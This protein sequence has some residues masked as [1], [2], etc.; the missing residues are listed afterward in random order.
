MPSKQRDITCGLMDR[1]LHRGV[2]IILAA[3]ISGCSADVVRFDAP[4]LDFDSAEAQRKSQPT[5]EAGSLSEQSPNASAAPMTLTSKPYPPPSATVQSDR[6]VQLSTTAGRASQPLS[7]PQTSV[8]QTSAP[9]AENIQVATNE[10]GQNATAPEASGLQAASSTP[11]QITVR[12]G[13]TLYRIARR[14]NMTVSSLKKANGL[15]NDVIRPGQVLTLRSAVAA[16]PANSTSS[17][18][19][20]QQ[21]AQAG[22]TK[23]HTVKTGETLYS[24]ARRAGVS[25]A[26]LK[27]VNNI[28]DPRQLRSGQV[29][30]LPDTGMQTQA[31][32]I[33]T[34]SNA[35]TDGMSATG[36]TGNRPIIVN[37]KGDQANQ[38]ITEPAAQ[39][40]QSSADGDIAVN[41]PSAENVRTANADLKFRWPVTGRIIRGFGRRAD[42]TNND[43]IN[44]AVPVGTDI[45]ASEKGTVA[46]AGDELQGYG[47]LILIR[48]A[49]GYVSVYA[50]LARIIASRG[51]TV[52]R[53]QVIAKAGKTGSVKQPQLHFELRQ[54]AKPIDPMP[55]LGR[56]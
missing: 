35:S 18:P 30:R 10:S 14:Y 8:S 12:P 2:G 51:D 56:M 1:L 32:E 48:H 9:Q 19:P 23:T 3:L 41:T 50:H 45:K 46:Y 38:R 7:E 44:I 22:S 31:A 39:T 11:Q 13:D 16:Q 17:G 43:G 27:R 54:G 53:G 37:P 20:P 36:T 5:Y 15:V 33:Q 40:S 29:L 52:R 49:N 42:G 4:S 24:I 25:V 55:Y 34:G 26:Q 6:L 47:N 28:D 21:P